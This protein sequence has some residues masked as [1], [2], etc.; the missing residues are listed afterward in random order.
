MAS[1][2][3]PL[4]TGFVCT[5]LVVALVTAGVGTVL[6]DSVTATAVTA[7]E[8]TSA[9]TDTAAVAQTEADTVNDTAATTNGSNQSVRY[10]DPADL[11]TTPPRSTSL[12]RAGIQIAESLG[13]RLEVSAS[14]AAE[15]DYDAAASQL[16][17]AYQSDVVK[18][19]D[20]A[21]ATENASDEELAAA[22]ASAGTNQRE[23]IGTAEEFQTLYTEYQDARASQNTTRARQ[24]AQELAATTDELNQTSGNLTDAYTELAALNE[25][26]AD[27]AQR[28]I[29]QTLTQAEQLSTNA[30]ES[31]YIE[32]NVVVTSVSPT[33]SP[34]RPFVISGQ[35][36]DS[37]GT[38]LANRTIELTTPR[39]TVRTQTDS[40]GT[41][42][43]T[44]TPIQLPAGEPS[45]SVRYTPV[46]TSGYLG[47]EATASPT[48]VAR[49]ATIA[50][51]STPRTL[52]GSSS[53][54]VSGTAL[55]DGEA[56]G[57]V[58]VRVRLGS[59]TVAQ[60][61][62]DQTGAFNLSVSPPITTEA[63]EKLLTVEAG[64]TGQAV[65]Y[66]QQQRSVTV[67]P[68]ETT[69]E[70]DVT[71]SNTTTVAI[72][73]QLTRSDGEPAGRQL[74]PVSVGGRSVGYLQTDSRGRF[75]S[76]F[77]LTEDHPAIDGTEQT[78]DVTTQF[79]NTTTHLAPAE[80][81][82]TVTFFP[83]QGAFGFGIPVLGWVLGAAGL[84]GMVGGSI[85]LWRYQSASSAGSE[86]AP[87][88]GSTP[89]SPP[90]ADAAT[91]EASPATLFER[92]EATVD[93][94]P[95]Q[96][97]QMGYLATRRALVT[98][99]SDS[100]THL[101]P[102]ATH[103]EVYRAVAASEGVD[104]ELTTAVASL[105]NVY[106]RCMY[107]T[108]EPTTEDV[109]SALQPVQAYFNGRESE[110]SRS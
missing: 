31:T 1:T 45:V 50:I 20:I 102:S 38:A 96:A 11:S 35:L 101:N 21:E 39:R 33:A 9:L 46:E 56:V 15:Q 29:E 55:V 6:V 18:L 91:P 86:T 52:S 79:A 103:G 84:V 48:V 5:L 77:T 28:R 37:D 87:S 93:S 70:M 25:S 89:D 26:Q 81:T 14:E 83:T 67:A 104:A 23:A 22:L 27:R 10:V 85:V 19:T 90:A 76:T 100:T 12:E 59:T 62:T 61:T 44:H 30:Q 92:A 63:G 94:T 82:S 109:R 80:A 68:I 75:T 105:T 71:R 42:R 13:L 107:T 49:N 78:V 3:R 47:S 108:A 43:L 36:T 60:T 64:R 58:P 110:S 72:D 54:T 41:F 16:G 40:T 74:L 73:G 88:S 2:L 53:G 66:T 51:D 17:P 7:N 34:H 32:T 65:G 97:L 4:R 57:D 98:E 95:A 24:L 8:G 106:E 99:L 69:L